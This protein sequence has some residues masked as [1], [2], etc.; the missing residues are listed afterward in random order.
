MNEDRPIVITR[1]GALCLDRSATG[2]HDALLDLADR[3]ERVPCHGD[4]AYRW[5]SESLEDR[6]HAAEVCVTACPLTRPRSRT[7]TRTPPRFSKQP[8][9]GGHRAGQEGARK[10]GPISSNKEEPGKGAVT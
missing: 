10:H 5:T 3:G 9:T 8:G 1:A 6:R 2:I 4:A 7:R